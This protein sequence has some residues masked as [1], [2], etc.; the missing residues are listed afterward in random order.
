MAII[1][2]EEK[3]TLSLAAGASPAQEHPQ[4]PGGLPVV[5]RTGCSTSQRFKTSSMSQMS[6]SLGRTTARRVS[7]AAPAPASTP[8]RDPAHAP[9]L[10]IHISGQPN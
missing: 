1:K 6:P 2:E 5:P 3:E 10:P 8:L 9:A 7:V 4:P